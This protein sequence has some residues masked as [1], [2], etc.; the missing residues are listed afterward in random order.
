[1]ATS[2]ESTNQAL[3][4]SLKKEVLRLNQEN[5][6]MREDLDEARSMNLKFKD[7]AQDLMKY[8]EKPGKDSKQK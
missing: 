1:L 6:K 2:N 5:K 3:I 8:Y 4:E 7:F